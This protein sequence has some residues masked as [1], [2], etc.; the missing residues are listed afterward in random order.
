MMYQSD[1]EGLVFTDFDFL[2]GDDLVVFK[3][4]TSS[5]GSTGSTGSKGAGP[6]A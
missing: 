1:G 4:L 5:A 6:I 2:E 3:V